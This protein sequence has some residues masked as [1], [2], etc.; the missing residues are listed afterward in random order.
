D[1]DK[2][3][4]ALH[5]LLELDPAHVVALSALARLETEQRHWNEA[6]DAYQ[7]ALATEAA[8]PE[9]A[10]DW[11]LALA[12]ILLD[13]LADAEQ[14][15]P[16]LQA[17]LEFNPGDSDALRMLGRVYQSMGRLEDAAQVLDTLAGS[18]APAEAA[19]I[20]VRLA[21]IRTSLEQ[22]DR[23]K[24]HLGEA[25]KLIRKDVAALTPL[26]AWSEK[27]SD[28]ETVAA[29]LEDVLLSAPASLTEAMVP[30]RIALSKVL[31]D[32]LDRRGDAEREAR[33]AATS[34]PN[35]VEAQLLAARLQV[36]RNEARR[37]AT[38]AIAVDPFNR[39]AYEILA[40]G[41]VQAQLPDAVG[42]CNQ[43][44]CVLGDRSPEAVKSADRAAAGGPAAGVSLGDDGL[45]RFVTHP[46]LPEWGRELLARAGHKAQ[47]FM[48][49][50]LPRY[51][52]QQ[53]NPLYAASRQVAEIFGFTDFEV[54]LTSAQNIAVAYDG[55]K[56]NRIL[57][58]PL[59]QAE[60][61]AEA[62]Y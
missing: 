42:R 37:F 61:L 33:M 25:A 39:E 21:K 45:M 34:D 31:A 19:E 50:E 15:E 36:E 26:L 6:V 5:E 54:F 4:R 29:L 53:D 32:H 55:E 17:M 38:A 52:I 18:C 62:R 20:H 47:I 35:N 2:A 40:S 48:L 49:P 27:S 51:P 7:R 41:F 59:A 46:K 22:H 23:A 10:R 12:H 9:T 58:G 16:V 1:P 3:I 30:V 13:Q 43:V 24:D 57:F 44:L 14:A 28:F 56:P 8:A 60:N 11:R